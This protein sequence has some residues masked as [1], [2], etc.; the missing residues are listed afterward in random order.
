MN[1]CVHAGLHVDVCMWRRVYVYMY[2]YV[3]V[4]MYVNVYV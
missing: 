4:F 3:Y 2:V 1:V